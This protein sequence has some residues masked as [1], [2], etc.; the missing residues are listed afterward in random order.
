MR[1]SPLSLSLLLAA[2]V[3]CFSP[4]FL[5]TTSTSTSTRTRSAQHNL[6]HDEESFSSSFLP[7][8]RVASRHGSIL[9]MMTEDDNGANG[10]NNNNTSSPDLQME[11]AFNDR[12]AEDISNAQTQ[13]QTAGQIAIAL[14][15]RNQNET[16]QEEITKRDIEITNLL[17]QRQKRETKINRLKFQLNEFKQAVEEG[18]KQKVVA[19]KDLEF[20]RSQQGD[21][22]L[23][24]S[25]R[26]QSRYVRDVTM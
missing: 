6:H 20:L 9:S 23:L 3:T 16:N 4:T 26:V 24:E 15:E 1:P 2:D 25:L 13:T 5:G 8:D 18:E 22:D 19:E 10:D 17:Q 7:N 14:Q 21:I 12:I 11:T